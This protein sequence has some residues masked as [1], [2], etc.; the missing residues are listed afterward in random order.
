MD[1]IQLT[2]TRY[3]DENGRT[4]VA[5]IAGNS[6]VVGV[7]S[8]NIGGDAE[9]SYMDIR[10]RSFRLSDAEGGGAGTDVDREPGEEL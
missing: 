2:L 10:L 3:T 1:H 7:E 6:G 4:Q 8:L 9:G 5:L